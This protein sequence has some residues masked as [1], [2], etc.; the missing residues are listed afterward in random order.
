MVG[1]SVTKTED[2]RFIVPEDAPYTLKI[3]YDSRA[4]LNCNIEYGPT[5][6]QIPVETKDGT[7]EVLVDAAVLSHSDKYYISGYYMYNDVKFGLG[8]IDEFAE[9]EVTGN[10]TCPVYWN[11]CF[12]I[13][14]FIAHVKFCGP[15]SRF[16]PYSIQ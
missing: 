1:D 11:L 15:Y 16:S 10:D 2:G 6:S 5:P 3:T 9:L 4:L 8:K 7:G 12:L 14:G 13:W